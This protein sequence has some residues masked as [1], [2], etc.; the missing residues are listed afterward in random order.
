[1]KKFTIFYADDDEDDLMFFEEAVESLVDF[2]NSIDLKLLKDGKNLIDNIKECQDE[3]TV[4]FLDLNM[5]YK[6]GFELL[7]EIRN[8]SNIKNTPIIIYST[9]SNLDT[10]DKSKKLGAD[11]YAIKPNSF[12]DLKKLITGAVTLNWSE[13]TGPKKQFIFNKLIAG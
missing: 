10:I 3:N 12:G 1:M 6:S 11:F 13:N 7:S 2:S 4:V 9:S 5:S 8:N